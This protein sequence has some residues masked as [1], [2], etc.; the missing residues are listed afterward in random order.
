MFLHAIVQGSP[1]IP[2]GA[3]LGDRPERMLPERGGAKRP[4]YWACGGAKGPNN[5]GMGEGGGGIRS[6]RSPR[7]TPAG[8][9]ITTTAAKCTFSANPRPS[10][11]G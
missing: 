10:L 3:A 6:G 7:A 11:R 2:V 5:W 1:P 9:P 8:P 4:N